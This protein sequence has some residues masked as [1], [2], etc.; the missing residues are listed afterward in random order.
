MR[1]FE[2]TA[3]QLAMVSRFKSQFYFLSLSDFSIFLVAF[4]GLNVT[5]A[6]GCA[7]F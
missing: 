5:D 7:G 1:Q 6:N 3:S 4:I 2:N